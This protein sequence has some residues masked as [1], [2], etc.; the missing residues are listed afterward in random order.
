MTD[1]NLITASG[2]DLV[3]FAYH[4]FK[5]LDVMSL[6]RTFYYMETEFLRTPGI[7]QQ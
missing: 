7:C 3:E 6:A 5:K 4:I 1:G 2:L